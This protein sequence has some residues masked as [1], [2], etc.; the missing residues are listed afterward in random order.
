M[1]PVPF[2]GIGVS[3]MTASLGRLEASIGHQ[4]ALSYML[5]CALS[6][7][8]VLYTPISTQDYIDCP[9]GCG[10]PNDM[11]IS[12]KSR[13]HFALLLSSDILCVRQVDGLGE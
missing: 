5:D 3:L 6:L 8:T 4:C 13:R 7:L 11:M 2:S 9:S 10:Y 12:K 1:I